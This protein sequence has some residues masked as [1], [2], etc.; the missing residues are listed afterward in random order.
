MTKSTERVSQFIEHVKKELVAGRDEGAT[1]PIERRRL[2]TIA[3]ECGTR[4]VA[5]FLSELSLQLSAA[6]LHTEPPLSVSALRRDDWIRFSTEPFPPAELLFP[7]ERDLQKFVQACLGI[8]PFR[9]LRPYQEGRKTL[10]WEFRLPDGKRI[11]L[12]CEERTKTGHGDLVAIELKRENQRGTVEQMT[13][14]LDG[15]RARFKSRSVRGMIITSHG[16]KAATPSLDGARA[17]GYRIEWHC[18]S[19]NFKPF[20]DAG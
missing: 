4:V 5:G 9:G 1:P 7:R 13:A 11:D 12:L 17:K 19:V 8:G 14:Y 20:H 15:L 6:G 16:D 18:Y 3:D 10:G 2:A